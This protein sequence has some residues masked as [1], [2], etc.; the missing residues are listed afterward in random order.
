[1]ALHAPN[2]PNLP[3]PP[4][5]VPEA[6]EDE[7]VS[8]PDAKYTK[9]EFEVSPAAGVAARCRVSWALQDAP[10]CLAWRE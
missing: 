5:G 8:V 6:S 7:I 2:S 4:Q 10:A 3:A 1:M 9:G